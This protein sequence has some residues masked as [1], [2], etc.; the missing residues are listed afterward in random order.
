M[1]RYRQTDREESVRA[2]DVR[3]RV[4]IYEAV[5]G[6]HHRI[7]SRFLLAERSRVL[8]VFSAAAAAL[9]NWR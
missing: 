5:A 8:L 1:S 9:S 3:T 2:G 6:R 7:V 4:Q